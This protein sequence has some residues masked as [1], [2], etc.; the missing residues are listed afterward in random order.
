MGCVFFWNISR[1]TGGSSSS[2]VTYRDRSERVCIVHFTRV[3]LRLWISIQV[4]LL[5]WTQLP[6]LK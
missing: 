1:Q 6:V 5:G 4:M 2:R 3:M